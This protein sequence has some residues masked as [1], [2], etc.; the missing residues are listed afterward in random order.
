MRL[1]NLPT[2]HL[3]R[4]AEGERQRLVK[5]PVGHAAPIIEICYGVGLIKD[6]L[7]LLII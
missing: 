1:N 7:V 6:A 4:F 2:N 5:C 3:R